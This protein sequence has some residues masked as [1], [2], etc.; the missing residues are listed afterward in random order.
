M[1]ER[2]WTRGW[3]ELV[4][5][6][7]GAKSDNYKPHRPRSQWGALLRYSS[8]MTRSSSSSSLTC[9]APISSSIAF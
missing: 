7:N 4:Q 8:S 2:G 3:R 9:S 1:I 6:Q 5:Y